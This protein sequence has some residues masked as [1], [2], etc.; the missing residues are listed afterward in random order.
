MR[1][2]AEA[3]PK[4][5]MINYDGIWLELSK[6]GSQGSYIHSS[7]SDLIA[8]KKVKETPQNASF[9]AGYRLW[10]KT[11]GIELY[12]TDIFV[13][14]EKYKYSGFADALGM[15]S[16]GDVVVIDFKSGNGVYNTH[17]IQLAAYCKAL[18]ESCNCTVSYNTNWL[19]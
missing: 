17:A 6:R 3:A 1:R 18:E 7:I 15:N 16:N 11:F 14:S 2:I 9:L 12:Y 8:G 10:R 4:N 19:I 13:K 5:G